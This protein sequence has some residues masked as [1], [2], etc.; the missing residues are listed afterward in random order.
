MACPICSRPTDQ[1]YR[2][3]CSKRC[4]DRDLAK[5]FGGSYAIPDDTPADPEALDEAL[6]NPPDRKPH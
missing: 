2:P 6:Q 1:A 3:F 4:A 5:W